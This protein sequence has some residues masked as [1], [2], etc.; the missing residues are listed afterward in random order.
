MIR[1]KF[2]QFI[3]CIKYQL[4]LF[5]VIDIVLL[6]TMIITGIFSL[7]APL[8]PSFFAGW[9]STYLIMVLVKNNFLD[10][11]KSTVSLDK[12]GRP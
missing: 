10:R 1:I 8:T 3:G 6:S 12:E 2:L 9:I 4:S 7:F 11:K 5:T